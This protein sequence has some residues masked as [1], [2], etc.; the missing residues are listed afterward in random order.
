MGTVDRGRDKSQLL[1]KG[2]AFWVRWGVGA[3]PQWVVGHIT[4]GAFRISLAQTLG[5][6]EAEGTQQ[7]PSKPS[8]GI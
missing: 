8:P 2:P 7:L 4:G 3:G 5:I 6:C 1:S